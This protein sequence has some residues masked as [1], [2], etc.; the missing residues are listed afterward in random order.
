MDVHNIWTYLL[1]KR[2][3]HRSGNL[4]CCQGNCVLLKVRVPNY[5]KF[6]VG[7]FIMCKL[8]TFHFVS[9]YL[10]VS[11]NCFSGQGKGRNLCFY[12]E[13]QQYFTSVGKKKS[14]DTNTSH[15]KG[16]ISLCIC[17]IILLN[18]NSMIVYFR[19]PLVSAVHLVQM[20]QLAER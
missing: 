3:R 4:V 20:A 2:G 15:F 1:E 14:W 13:W 8:A 18:E 19:D 11:G 7:F 10:M 12:Y 17:F 6:A 9:H 5:F 16:K